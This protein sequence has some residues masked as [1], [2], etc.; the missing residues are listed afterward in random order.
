MS[1]PI[2]QR[3]KIFF[4]SRKNFQQL[5]EKNVV[6][7]DVEEATGRSH[8]IAVLTLTRESRNGLY[9]TN[10]PVNLWDPLGLEAFYDCM[11]G[12]HASIIVS[13]PNSKTGYTEYSF[14]PTRGSWENPKATWNSPALME[15]FN[16]RPNPAAILLKTTP[17]QD[18][19]LRHSGD[20]RAKNPGTYNPMFNNCA[21]SAKG[22]ASRCRYIAA[23]STKSHAFSIWIK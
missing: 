4:P 20:E 2:E 1:V 16:S 23:F 15:K 14:T 9:V 8:L 13:D 21:D 18:A 5:E 19:K 22:D 10:N 11:G 7:L 3:Q 6:V 17:E 12:G